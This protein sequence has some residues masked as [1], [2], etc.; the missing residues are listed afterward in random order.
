MRCAPQKSIMPIVTSRDAA[1]IAEIRA[2]FTFFL[3]DRY[4][5]RL[6]AVHLGIR[7]DW[8]PSMVE[9]GDE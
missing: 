9:D 3:R 5:K 2:V 6:N 7:Y 4:V 1:H 8:D